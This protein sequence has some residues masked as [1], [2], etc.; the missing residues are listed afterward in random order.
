MRAARRQIPPADRAASARRF[1]VVADRAFLL[2]PGARIG[3]YQPHGHEA[4]VSCITAR[5]WQ[6]GCKL[7]LPVITSSRHSRMEFFR[8]RPGALLRPNAFGIGEPDP[9]ASERIPVRHLD[10]VLMPL[11]AFDDRGWRLGSGAGYYDRCFRHLD[12]SRTWR[13]PKLVG[14]AFAQQ[15]V[16]EIEPGPWDIPMDAVLT[17][18]GLQRFHPLR[19]GTTP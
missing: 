3:V 19:S 14:V 10:I 18:Y 9:S 1:A 2:R 15:R 8:Y 11:V 16:T 6:R 13:R 17:Q 5:A 4:D 7:Y 12:V